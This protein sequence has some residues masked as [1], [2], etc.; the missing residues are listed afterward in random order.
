MKFSTSLS[1]INRN[2]GHKSIHNDM[3]KVKVDKSNNKTL[4]NFP[5]VLYP[6]GNPQNKKV[7]VPSECYVMTYLHVSHFITGERMQSVL[8]VDPHHLS[9]KEKL[10]VCAR[11]NVTAEKFANKTSKIPLF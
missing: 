9:C 1:L 10:L 5:W 11:S 6:N 7:W 4:T 2:T 8:C 3:G